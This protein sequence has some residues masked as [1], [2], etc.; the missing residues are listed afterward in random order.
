MSPFIQIAGVRGAKEA[1]MLAREGV[2]HVGFPLR[3]PVHA[4][5]TTESEAADMISLLPPKTTPVLITYL[6]DAQEI[7]R[8]AAAL[9]VRA[10]QLHGDVPAGQCA[11]LREIAPELT[12]IKSLVVREGNAAALLREAEALAPWV[13]LFITDTFD[14]ATGA[15]GATG[16]TH[17]WAVSRMLVERAGRPLILAGGLHPGNVAE[18]VRAVRPAGVDAHT[19]V[20]DARGDKDPAKV[21]E[22]VRIARRELARLG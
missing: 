3:L 8:F 12:V 1:L 11:R 7:R 19:G 18:A 16:R 10:V 21:R 20:E 15:S 14:S 9:R 22:F 13:D 2:T 6:S 4:E 5:D 17:D